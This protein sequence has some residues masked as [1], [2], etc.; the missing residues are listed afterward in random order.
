MHYS[1]QFAG[2]ITAVCAALHNVCIHYKL[3]WHEIPLEYEIPEVPVDEANDNL[4]AS[5]VRIKIMEALLN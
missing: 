3:Q 2:K 5:N 1:P 4:S